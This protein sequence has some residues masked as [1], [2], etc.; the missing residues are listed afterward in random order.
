MNDRDNDTLGRILDRPMSR[1][2]WAR[3]RR[4]DM[5]DEVR[6]GILCLV[7]LA[8]VLRACGI[9]PWE[10]QG[11]SGARPVMAAEQQTDTNVCGQMHH[12][13]SD[14]YNRASEAGSAIDGVAAVLLACGA[15]GERIIADL[16]AMVEYKRVYLPTLEKSDPPVIVTAP[17]TSPA[18]VP[19]A[20]SPG[21]GGLINVNTASLEELDSLPDV[22]PV[23]AQR[24]IDARP[25]K[26][27]A[28]MDERVKGLGAANTAKICPLITF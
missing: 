24:I 9:N 3:R 7:V 17:P 26:D 1:H 16:R 27:C 4:A 20:A 11:S 6:G 18:P 13:W 10:G 2:P 8:V 15:D 28:D 12:Q 21:T 14:A 25:L 19:T 23:I 5:F 22:G